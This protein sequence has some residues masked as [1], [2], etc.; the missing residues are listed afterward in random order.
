M[1]MFISNYAYLINIL[2]RNL[3]KFWFMGLWVSSGFWVQKLSNKEIV[4][5]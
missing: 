2:P 3:Y 5:V 4:E 1:F